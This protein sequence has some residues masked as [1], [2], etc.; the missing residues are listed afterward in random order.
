MSFNVIA[1]LK[2]IPTGSTIIG[3]GSPN[4]LYNLS[5][6][7]GAKGGLWQN[8]N[9]EYFRAGCVSGGVI[10]GSSADQIDFW[11][12]ST[13][14]H[15]NLVGQSFN[16]SSDLRLKTEIEPLE[17]GLDI[18]NTLNPYSYYFKTDIEQG[19]KSL[20]YGFV[21]QEVNE[22]LPALVDTSRGY[23][24]LNY[25]EIIP[26][27]VKG[28]K[29]Q[30]EIISNQDSIITNL[31][32]TIN[33]IKAKIEPE[34]QSINNED[35]G[36]KAKLYQNKPNPFKETTS[37][38]FELPNEYSS[39]NLMIFDLRGTLIKSYEISGQNNGEVIIEGRELKAG[40]Y[41]Y[42]LFVDDI[43][44]DTKKMILNN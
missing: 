29:E 41:L 11:Y 6:T 1:Q 17:S 22:I 38:N 19:K 16:N 2:V 7:D 26:F 37:I 25:I 13:T 32:K 40:M 4:T 15:N 31:E 44:V 5:L 30:Q 9:N 33:S 42:S 35:L 14:G 8:R 28:I 36:S 21:A 27:L 34:T 20:H 43:E 23:L 12:S 10:I 18:L 39:A 3:P 24:T